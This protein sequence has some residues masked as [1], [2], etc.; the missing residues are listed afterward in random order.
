VTARGVVWSTNEN[1]TVGL[2]EGITDDGEGTGEFVSFLTGLDPQTTYHVRAYAINSQGTA[3]G[4]HIQF[5]TDMLSNLYLSDLVIDDVICFSATENIIVAGDGS[6]FVVE[7]GAFVELVAG[8]SVILKDGTI[9]QYGAG[10][11]ARITTDGTYCNRE[12]SMLAAT[13]IED[14]SFPAT[15]S[16]G[17]NNTAQCKLYPNPVK[18]KL[19]IEFTNSD[20]KEKTGV[21]VFNLQGEL[22]FQDI[23]SGMNEY[24]IDFMDKKP[25]IYVVRIRMESSVITEKILKQ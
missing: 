1:P 15:T 24:V 19:V 23:F 18:D 25:G 4:Q 13:M 20:H 3:Y 16:S 7:S 6:Q 17:I 9:I 21:H 8:Q 14:P 2:N 10:F 22:V 12:E 11:I 5:A